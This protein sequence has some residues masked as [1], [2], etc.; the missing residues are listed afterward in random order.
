M[1]KYGHYLNTGN[2]CSLNK[3][4]TKILSVKVKGAKKIKAPLFYEYVY[5]IINFVI[6]VPLY[7]RLLSG[8]HIGKG[9][10]R[11]GLYLYPFHELL[12]W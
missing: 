6:I 7:E 12:I 2:Y 10:W 8:L 5:I 4:D 11:D 3:N 1:T 9:H